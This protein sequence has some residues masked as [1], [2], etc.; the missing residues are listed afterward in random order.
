[1]CV[2]CKCNQANVP[3]YARSYESYVHHIIRF[4]LWISTFAPSPPSTPG[5]IRGDVD[6][7]VGTRTQSQI[8]KQTSSGGGGSVGQSN[9]GGGNPHVLGRFLGILAKLPPSNPTLSKHKSFNRC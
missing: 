6:P 3:S 4:L 5:P 1:M 7:K 2:M 9:P 8:Y